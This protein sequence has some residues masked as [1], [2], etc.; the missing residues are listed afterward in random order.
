MK[1]KL[2]HRRILL[3]SLP[4]SFFTQPIA[5]ALIKLG[6]KVEIFNYLSPRFANRF[7]GFT[8][9]LGLIPK[10]PYQSLNDRMINQALIEKVHQFQP[11]YLLVI[12]GET[13]KPSTIQKVNKLGVKT[14]N[15][16]PDWLIS[17]P[18]LKKNAPAYLVMISSCRRTAQ[19]LTTIAKKSLYLPFAAS[20]EKQISSHPKIYNISFIG[21]YTPRRE[22]YFSAI[23]DLGLHIWGYS[24]WQKSSLK[25]ITKG[26]IS[27]QKTQA[28]LRQSKL[29]V[30]ILTGSD[31]FQP[32]AV[33]VRTFEATGAKVCLL[34]KDSKLLHRYFQ[35]Q[36]EVIT[37]VS[38]RDLRQKVIYY[39]SHTRE[40]NTIARAG[41][42]RTK[43]S[44]TFEIRLQQLFKSI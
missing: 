7:L 4:H 20:I 38:P 5:G 22:K 30:N 44:H 3:A 1:A 10:K 8:Y 9:N 23:K 35:P 12:K 19:K 17:W 42:E 37:F 18:W 28:I 6:F 36:K 34:I 24:D 26:Q 25:S 2:S 29:T 13:I 14:I 21:Q 33:N 27:P 41:Y 40:R 43:K 16:F 39:L 32:D 15:W 31:K 11:D